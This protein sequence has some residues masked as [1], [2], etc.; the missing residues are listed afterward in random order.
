LENKDGQNY[1]KLSGAQS[2]GILKSMIGC[3]VLI[4]VPAGSGALTDGQE[5]SALIVGDVNG[6]FIGSK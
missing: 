5:V 6:A 3:N 4:D 1:I 2:N